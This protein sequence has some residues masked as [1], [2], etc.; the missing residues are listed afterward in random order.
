MC[1]LEM[2][3]LEIIGNGESGKKVTE[4]NV[5]Q[6][7][8]LLEDER[9]KDFIEKC[10]RKNPEERWTARELLFHPLL[11]EVHSLKLL[12]AHVLVRN[13]GKLCECSFFLHPLFFFICLYPNRF[14]CSDLSKTF[15]M[16]TLV[17]DSMV[18]T[19][20]YI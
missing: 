11:F 6:T 2:A 14:G 17:V 15:T 18:D 4:E 5:R 3:A 9:Q 10:L 7:I 1:A 13:S 16:Y 8:D 12:A 20:T 19:S